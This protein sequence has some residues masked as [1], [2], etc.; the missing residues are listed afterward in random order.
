MKLVLTTENKNKKTR[1]PHT[2]K[3]AQCNCLLINNFRT[4]GKCEYF[5]FCMKYSIQWRE[6]RNLHTSIWFFYLNLFC[7]MFHFYTPWKG[8]LTSFRGYRNGTL[9]WNGLKSWERFTELL[10]IP[11]SRFIREWFHAEYFVK[12]SLHYSITPPQSQLRD[13]SFSA[14]ANF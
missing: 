6:D 2:Q 9:R 8:F 14:Y 5:R 11:S 12:H 3:L 1:I 10:L 13:H 4:Y 7:P